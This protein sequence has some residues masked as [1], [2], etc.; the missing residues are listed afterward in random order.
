M[1]KMDKKANIDLQNTSQK[2]KNWET[3]TPLK[4]RAEFMYTGR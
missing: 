1:T 3:R 2:T 4:I